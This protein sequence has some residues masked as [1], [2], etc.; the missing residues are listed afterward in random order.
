MVI[1][2]VKYSRLAEDT[3]IKIR[4]LYTSM[5]ITLNKET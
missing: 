1:Y 2:Y 4:V 3:E 5:D